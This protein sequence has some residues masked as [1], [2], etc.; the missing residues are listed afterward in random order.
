M[1]T[2]ILTAIHLGLP[3]GTN[4]LLFSEEVGFLLTSSI[5]RLSIEYTTSCNQKFF[6]Y[7]YSPYKLNVGIKVPF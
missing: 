5:G 3:C 1:N 2:E 6:N 7:N 4:V